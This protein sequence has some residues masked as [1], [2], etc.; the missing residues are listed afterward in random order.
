M[1]IKPR[2]LKKFLEDARESISVDADQ[3]P[4][5]LEAPDHFLALCK[6]FRALVCLELVQRGSIPCG[7][8]FIADSSSDQNGDLKAVLDCVTSTAGRPLLDASSNVPRPILAGSC[9]IAALF[10][11]NCAA[12]LNAMKGCDWK[13]YQTEPFSNNLLLG[14]I[15]CAESKTSFKT[16][17]RR[18]EEVDDTRLTSL[19]HLSQ[20]VRPEEGPSDRGTSSFECEG[21]RRHLCVFQLALERIAAGSYLRAATSFAAPD[22]PQFWRRCLDAILRIN[23]IKRSPKYFDYFKFHTVEAAFPLRELRRIALAKGNA[24]RASELSLR[25][26]ESYLA[27]DGSRGVR[28]EDGRGALPDLL[29]D[30]TNIFWDVYHPSQPSS[31]ANLSH[32]A[33][34]EL[35]YINID[36]L[37]ASEKD[38]DLGRQELS[39]LYKVVVIRA[40]LAV[41]D[42]HIAAVTDE[43]LEAAKRRSENS[44]SGVGKRGIVGLTK[45]K[46]KMVDSANLSRRCLV[47]ETTFESLVQ[48]SQKSAVTVSALALRDELICHCASPEVMIRLVPLLEA[49]FY[50]LRRQMTRL[51]QRARAIA[52]FAS[53]PGKKS[54][55]QTRNNADQAWL[56]L[57]S[58]IQPFLSRIFFDKT[59][60]DID[61]MLI[62]MTDV[63][64]DAV[65]Y[66]CVGLITAQWMSPHTVKD[67]VSTLITA[68]SDVK[69]ERSISEDKRRRNGFGKDVHATPWDAS[70]KSE[71]LQIE[72]ATLAQTFRQILCAM[73]PISPSSIRRGSQGAVKLAKANDRYLIAQTGAPFALFL[74]SWS[75]TFQHPP[76]PFCTITQGR[77][78]CRTARECL[79]LSRDVWGRTT[80][81]IENALVKLGEADLESLLPGGDVAKGEDIYNSVLISLKAKIVG[82]DQSVVDFLKAH[83]LLGLS[84]VALSGIFSSNST[85]SDEEEENSIAYANESLNILNRFRNKES[86]PLPIP[87]SLVLYICTSR[88]LVAEALIREGKLAEALTFLEQAVVDAPLDYDTTFALGSFRLRALMN[89]NRSNVDGGNLRAAQ[90]QLL[91]AAKLNPKKADPFALLGILYEI[92]G[93]KK[94]AIGC[95]SKSLVIESSH[96]VSGRG[97]LRLEPFND[98][99]DLCIA[100]TQ[101]MSLMSGWAWLAI[102]LYNSL[103]KGNDDAAVVC[104]QQALRARDIEMMRYQNLGIF[105]SI[106]N[107]ADFNRL[108]ELGLTWAELAGCY[109]R[110]NKYSASLRAYNLASKAC[111][112]KI[113]PMTA[114]AWANVEIE[115]GL[116]QEGSSR[117]E[118]ILQMSNNQATEMAAFGHSSAMLSIARQYSQEGKFGLSLSSLELGINSIEYLVGKD[119]RRQESFS[120]HPVCA[121]KLLGDLYTEAALLPASV[122]GNLDGSHFQFELVSRGEAAY[123]HAKKAV[124]TLSRYSE[125]SSIHVAA[126]WYDLGV[127]FICQARILTSSLGKDCGRGTK[128]TM[129][130]FNV[131]NSDFQKVIE[132][133]IHHFFQAAVAL[134]T[135]SPAWIGLGTAYSYKDNL[136]A[137]HC[138]CRAIQLEKASLEAWG[139]IGMIYVN[140][141]ATNASIEAFD[142]LTQVAN[143][144]LIWI[145]RGILLED[146]GAA[147]LGKACFTQASDSYRAAM[148]VGNKPAALLGL[149]LTSRLG[150]STAINGFYANSAQRAAKAES[151]GAMDLYLHSTGKSDV[152]A[153]A[154]KNIYVAEN[155]IMR[156]LSF[157][158]NHLRVDDDYDDSALAMVGG[159]MERLSTNEG[160]TIAPAT[161][162]TSLREFSHNMNS[163]LTQMNSVLTASKSLLDNAST[164]NIEVGKSDRLKKARLKL[165]VH[166]DDGELFLHYAKLL[167]TTFLE[168]DNPS[169]HSRSVVSAT[170][171]RGLSI[172]LTNVSDVSLLAPRKSTDIEMDRD[173]H[174][175]SLQKSVVPNVPHAY[176]LSEAFALRAWLPQ[177]AGG[178]HTKLHRS[179]MVDVRRSLLL[180]PENLYSRG[181][182]TSNG[183]VPL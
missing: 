76:W 68:C 3:T 65:I 138:L 26:A 75:G 59:S 73:P 39:L 17:L 42:R 140:C 135:F 176:V 107:P 52:N 151:Q 159:L 105:Y 114:C 91:K 122:F 170:V 28:A 15:V 66:S 153:L 92:S 126:A 125:C 60:S 36:V 98:V 12:A 31:R 168:Q 67:E 99:K 167:A 123:E 149:S 85:K 102:G 62:S 137:Q 9:A 147:G 165:R 136:L 183:L 100:A 179:T 72:S 53:A 154:L 169:N 143:T 81:M 177:N 115:L 113:P 50:L 144:P 148:Q 38:S 145:G 69:V 180:D 124:T 182:L 7:A 2:Q 158:D 44:D 43:K 133:S 23:L 37:L 116:I 160:G 57:I 10:A 119:W 77:V 134:N 19:L 48:E 152:V 1:S 104:L 171:E 120:K 90:L 6:N 84:R 47:E 55:H 61:L 78:I 16:A 86:L 112:G 49:A 4:C 103:S 146:E 34:G 157:E 74:I 56:D 166:P 83:C 79:E 172:L 71:Q 101:S 139:N 22:H 54:R 97:L 174:G 96:P 164:R 128:L 142:A 40:N 11:E 94:R 175:I 45:T 27:D 33:V 108:T 129:L 121:M 181:L 178:S 163:I 162:M 111:N 51:I 64:L 21:T 13:A 18:C 29:V 89:C 95:Y 8:P 88:Q 106:P 117:L 110:Q 132:K 14:S 30:I 80:T 118:H 70:E 82:A 93:D 5:R 63:Q 25:L 173:R 150:L 155:S 20:L 87:T 35:D 131:A 109:R 130:D 46:K 41:Q 141:D 156:L 58:F 32:L 161:L 127:N 24:S